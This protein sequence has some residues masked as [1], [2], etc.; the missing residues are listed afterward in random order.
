MLYYC[1]I[2]TGMLYML[3]IQTHLLYESTIQ[4][5]KFYEPAIQSVWACDTK[6]YVVWVCH[7]YILY[8]AAINKIGC[9]G[10]TTDLRILWVCNTNR[11]L[12]PG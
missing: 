2:Q 10:L 6:G 3:T 1:T 7:I 4:T 12:R 8:E 11:Y 5:G 9:M